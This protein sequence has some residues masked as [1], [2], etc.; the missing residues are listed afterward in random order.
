VKGSSIIGYDENTSITKK[1][2]KPEQTLT[3]LKAGSKI[4]L[5]K[6]M[7]NVKCKPKAA[8]GRINNETLLMK[9]VK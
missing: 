5:R 2:R 4:V 1:L 6:L 9:A 8:N 7:D 3:I